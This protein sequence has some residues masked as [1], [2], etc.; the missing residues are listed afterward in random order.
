[1]NTIISIASFDVLFGADFSTIIGI[2]FV[3]IYVIAHI[4]GSLGAAHE[5]SVKKAKN[6]IKQQEQELNDYMSERKNNAIPVRQNNE[7]EIIYTSRP[8]E[9]KKRNLRKPQPQISSEII[10]ALPNDQKNTRK[11]LAR[12]LPTQGQGTRFEASPRTLNTTLASTV[13]TNVNPD[14]ESLTGIYEQPAQNAANSGNPKTLTININDLLSTPEGI[15][16]SI[17]LSE[18]IN[19][20]NWG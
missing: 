2:I 17:I 3:V 15:R 10:N 16:N 13:E 20:P 4:I 1:M 7:Q 9:K 11:S 5:T 14:L 6:N 12:E 19:R 8:S 18:I